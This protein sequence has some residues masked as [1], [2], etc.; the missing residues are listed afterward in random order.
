MYYS[1]KFLPVLIYRDKHSM[2]A[3][4]VSKQAEYNSCYR[5][6]LIIRRREYRKVKLFPESNKTIKL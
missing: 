6:E 5:Q 1:R 3:I 4:G 2:P